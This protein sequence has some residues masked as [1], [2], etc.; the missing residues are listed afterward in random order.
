[1]VQVFGTHIQ[2]TGG[3]SY[4]T[5]T[6]KLPSPLSADEASFLPTACS[7]ALYLGSGKGT[8]ACLSPGR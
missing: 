3:A 4:V 8:C 1:V 2:V 6:E 7:F 5:E